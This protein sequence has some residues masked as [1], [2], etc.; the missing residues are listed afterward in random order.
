MLRNNRRGEMIM[1]T[2]TINKTNRKGLTQ[3]KKQ[4]FKQIVG[5]FSSKIDLNKVRNE[6][7]NENN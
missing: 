7:K 3:T 4:G 1:S 6:W 2:V 5:K